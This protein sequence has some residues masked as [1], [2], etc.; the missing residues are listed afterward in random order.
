MD[1]KLRSTQEWQIIVSLLSK[2][3]MANCAATLVTTLVYVSGVI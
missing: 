3:W 2:F 1:Q